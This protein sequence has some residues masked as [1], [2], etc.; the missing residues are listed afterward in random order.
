MLV[1]VELVS[2][3]YVCVEVKFVAIRRS[4]CYSYPAVVCMLNGVGIYYDRV[5]GML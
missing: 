1:L 4:S 5:N 2:A 3:D